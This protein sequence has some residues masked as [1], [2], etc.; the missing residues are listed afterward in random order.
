MAAAPGLL[1]ALALFAFGTNLWAVYRHV[2][3]DPTSPVGLLGVL[4]AAQPLTLGG[5]LAVLVGGL[6]L[7]AKRA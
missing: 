4:E 2:A 5:L 1:I 7:V 3:G 6:R